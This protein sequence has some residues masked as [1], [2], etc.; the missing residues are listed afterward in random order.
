M[1]LVALRDEIVMLCNP[2]DPLRPFNWRLAWQ[3]VTQEPRTV[4]SHGRLV[5]TEGHLLK[6]QA[7][8]LKRLLLG[9]PWVRNIAE[10]GFNGGH[11]SYVFLDSR[12]DVRVTSFDLG[13]HEYVNR[14]KSVIDN[15]FPGRHEL[16]I[17]D[18]RVTVPAFAAD[19]PDQHFDLIY[20][21]GGHD[22]NVARADI[23]NCRLFATDRT[24]VVMDDLEPDK[25]WG[26]G[27]VSAWL[28]AQSEGLIHQD[29]LVGDGIPV[30]GAG[31]E[32]IGGVVH[33]W[34]LGHYLRS[35][36][37]FAVPLND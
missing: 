35:G 21:D 23:E 37:A 36:T 33:R 8:F 22:L 31:I 10:V 12:P 25:E 6:L 16:V 20:I 32:E 4:V 5:P 2:T 18:S 13:E 14:A 3:F 27:P 30:L 34:A 28:A 7:H 1:G 26:M 29:V 17:G 15:L 19:R 24:I 9:H 11:S